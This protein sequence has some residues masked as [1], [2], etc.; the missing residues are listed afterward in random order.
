MGRTAT[1]ARV[2]IS[3]SHTE[4]LSGAKGNSSGSQRLQI[5]Q[6]GG[7]RTNPLMATIERSSSS[8]SSEWAIGTAFFDLTSITDKVPSPL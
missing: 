8:W 6:V 1:M 4:S 7:K 2:T 5:F 3:T